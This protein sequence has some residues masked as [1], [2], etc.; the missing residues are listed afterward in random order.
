MPRGGRAG[1]DN[2]LPPIMAGNHARWFIGPGGK[3]RPLHGFAA[4][5]DGLRDRRPRTVSRGGG[6]A[7]DQ[8][9]LPR[10]ERGRAR[11]AVPYGAAIRARAVDWLS[12]TSSRSRSPS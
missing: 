8:G 2:G 11:I 1:P 4:L 7:A 9:S 12:T 3:D 5:T 6:P 10:R